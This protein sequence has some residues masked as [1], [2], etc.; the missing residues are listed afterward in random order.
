MPL[1]IN[2]GLHILSFVVTLAAA[3]AV[4]F[5]RMRAARKPASIMKIVMPPIGM[6]TGFLMFLYPPMRIPFTW[7]LIA[8]AIGAV[9]FSYP[10]MLTTKFQVQGRRI[11]ARRSKAF[12]F[13]L[14]ALLVIRIAAH[15]YIE[16]F[17]TIYQTGAVF[18]I[19]ARC[20][21]ALARLYVHSVP[22]A[23]PDDRVNTAEHACFSLP[24]KGGAEDENA[25]QRAKRATLNSCSNCT[26]YSQGR[27]FQGSRRPA[28]PIRSAA[29]LSRAACA[30][31][32]LKRECQ[33]T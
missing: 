11:Y 6:S 8:F 12:I 32:P 1:S 28:F 33:K 7:A 23:D 18:F 2:S 10:L 16:A 25:G 19:L 3:L 13:I 30:Y 31:F 29:I 14:L 5:I 17:I 22:Q 26:F 9:A 21:V 4:I 24:G 15:S 27:R 20:H